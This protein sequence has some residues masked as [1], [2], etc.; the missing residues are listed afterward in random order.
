MNKYKNYYGHPMF[1]KILEN[2]A[3]L[4]SDKNKQYAT[5]DNPLGNFTRTAALCSKLF[6]PKI[7]N[8]PLAMALCYMA[9]QVDGVYEIVGEGK[10]GTVD[11]LKDKFSDIAVYSIIC[12]ILIDEYGNKNV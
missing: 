5:K 12:M 3:K 11:S 8:K 7:K 2:L 9:K 10:E 1:Y 4:H 6:N